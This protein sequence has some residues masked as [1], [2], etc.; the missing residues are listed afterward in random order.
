MNSIDDLREDLRAAVSPAT[1]PPDLPSLRRGAARRRDRRWAACALGIVV[2]L[3]LA[4][5]GIRVLTAHAGTAPAGTGPTGTP[6]A[7]QHVAVSRFDPLVRTVRLGWTPPGLTVT[8]WDTSVLSQDLYAG[9]TGDPSAADHGKGLNVEVRA[10]GVPFSSSEGG[11][12]V[13]EQPEGRALQPAKPVDGHPAQC[14][15]PAG[16][17]APCTALRW[18]Y[19]PNA[20]AQVAYAPADGSTTAQAAATVRHV[21]ETLVLDA[22]DAVTLPFTVTGDTAKLTPVATYVSRDTD[23]EF[24]W[25]ASLTLST[26]PAHWAPY[27]ATGTELTIDAGWMTG[28]RFHR[29][30]TPDTTIDGHPA[31]VDSNGLFAYGAGH[32]RIS[33]SVPTGHDAVAAYHDTH[34][35]PNPDDQRSWV[36]Q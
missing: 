9:P 1:P 12:G 25:D 32:L 8:G 26:D 18:E 5:T 17:T 24:R 34:L 6:S 19:A 23:A 21:A 15:A 11:I 27:S 20:Y 31:H 3:A 30:T 29:D 22:H 2:V 4:A 14:V 7:G 28:T 16:S 36:V 35:V 10:A 33:V 13:P